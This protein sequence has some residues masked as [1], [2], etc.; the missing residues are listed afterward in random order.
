MEERAGE[1]RLILLVSNLAH[2]QL[3]APLPSPTDIELSRR[4]PIFS[5]SPR[6]MSGE[7]GNSTMFDT[8]ACNQDGPPLPGPL[9]PQREEREKLPRTLA[10]H[11]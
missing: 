10:F 11:R 7:R 6:K 4:A 5:L 2:Q 9:L 1:R 3:D 8:S